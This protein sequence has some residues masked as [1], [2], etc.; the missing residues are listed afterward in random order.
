MKIAHVVFALDVS[1]HGED[2][3]VAEEATDILY[4]STIRMVG[5]TFLTVLMRICVRLLI[6]RNV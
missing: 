4:C 1:K 6:K 5:D 2:E 3:T